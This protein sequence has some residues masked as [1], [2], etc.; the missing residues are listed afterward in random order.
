LQPLPRARPALPRRPV[1]T[2]GAPKPGVSFGRVVEAPA[3]APDNSPQALMD[4]AVNLVGKQL[5]EE[6][7]LAESLGGRYV[8]MQLT[9]DRRAGFLALSALQAE[10]FLVKSIRRVWHIVD[11]EPIGPSWELTLDLGEPPPH[12]VGDYGPDD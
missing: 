11:C 4:R 12:S 7:A 3:E 1:Q 6:T 9:G 8:Q 2:A 5:P 10:G